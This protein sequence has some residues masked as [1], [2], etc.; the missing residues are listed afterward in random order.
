MLKKSHNAKPG[1]PLQ[2]KPRHHRLVEL[3]VLGF[4]NNEIAAELKYTP[5]RVSQLLAHQDIQAAILALRATTRDRSMGVLQD[6]IAKDARNT[7]DKLR[8]HRDDQDPQVSLRACHE[9]WDRQIP[10]RTEVKEEHTTR[11][12]IEAEDY[13]YLRQVAVE[14]DAPLEAEYTVE[15][16]ER[17]APSTPH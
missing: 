10:K 16:D 12:I 11:I 7:F 9:L 6:D 2:W 17:D 4:T 14:D 8:V 15:G 13:T 3:A 5:V 1:A